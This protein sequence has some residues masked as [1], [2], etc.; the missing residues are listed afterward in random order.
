MKL[1]RSTKNFVLSENTFH[2]QQTYNSRNVKGNHF[3]FNYLKTVQRDFSGKF[4]GG[5]VNTLTSEGPGSI[6]G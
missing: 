4:S 5:P 2:Y 3:F 6:P 1:K